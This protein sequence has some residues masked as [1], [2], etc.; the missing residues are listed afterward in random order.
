MSTDHK[1]APFTKP[2]IAL[3]V[4]GLLLASTTQPVRAGCGKKKGAYKLSVPVFFAT[5]RQQKRTKHGL[6]L[7]K[8]FI[9]PVTAITYGTSRKNSSISLADEKTLQK[10][11]SWG[12]TVLPGKHAKAAEKHAVDT[13][14]S[15]ILFEDNGFDSL[16][17]HL[18]D[19]LSKN[20]KEEFVIF[21]HGCCIDFECSMQ[22]AADLET[23]LKLPVVAYCWGCSNGYGGS[24]VAYPRSQERFNQFITRLLKAFPKERID[25]IGNS[26]GCH[27]VK[28]Y[29]LQQRPEDSG[30]ALDTIFLTRGD[31]DATALKS[32]LYRLKQHSSKLIFYVAKNDF[33]INLSGTLRWFFY[34]TQ[35][36]TRVG[37]SY[38]KLNM[39]PEVTVLDVSPLRL[40]HVIPYDS[41]ADVLQNAGLVPE[42]SEHYTY[43]KQQDNLYQ[44]RRIKN[45]PE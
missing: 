42:Q 13:K 19:A 8:Q 41:I 24:N 4:C 21:V 33:Q 30:R 20:G 16:V 38:S 10:L 37:H 45:R 29:C 3:V 40:G 43:E 34:P 17:V 39:I 44:V 15:T 7:G 27:L 9:D 5:D 25:M 26:I 11:K 18:K 6:T 1:F 2:V 23:S 32:Q 35:H 12:W 31:L 14:N 36:G 28:D 22:Q